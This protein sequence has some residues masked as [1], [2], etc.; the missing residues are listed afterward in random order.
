MAK[1]VNINQ[2]P[3]GDC[4]WWMAGLCYNRRV[5]TTADNTCENGIYRES[6]DITLDNLLL[7]ELAKQT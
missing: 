1:I 2:V 4:W 5:K 7:D 3:C 6:E